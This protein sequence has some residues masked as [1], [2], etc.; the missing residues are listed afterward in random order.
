[1]K[2]SFCLIFFIINTLAF[3]PAFA[4]GVDKD[5]EDKGIRAIIKATASPY[6]LKIGNGIGEGAGQ[7]VTDWI[8]TRFYAPKP[9]SWARAAY[10]WIKTGNKVEEWGPIG[11]LVGGY[12]G[13]IMLTAGTMILIDRYYFP[14][15][16][17]SECV[18]E[19]DPKFSKLRKGDTWKITEST[20][21][22]V[23][24]GYFVYWDLRKKE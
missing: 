15:K 4:M 24:L 16:R 18:G 5:E 10:A 3:S 19:G 12:I 17:L 13:S 20:L 8:I 6:T 22:S 11:S 1:M 9:G 21:L 7:F 23:G 2:K 14:W